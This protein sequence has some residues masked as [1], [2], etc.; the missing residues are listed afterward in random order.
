MTPDE[1]PVS[2]QFLQLITAKWVVKP[3]YVAAKLKLADHIKSGVTDV[4]SLA[5]KTGTKADML[6]RLL[7]AQIMA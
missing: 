6:Y 3:M 1:L 5:E 7:R 4:V 2:V